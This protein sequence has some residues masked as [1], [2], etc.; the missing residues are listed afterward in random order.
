MCAKYARI[1]VMSLGG[2]RFDKGVPGNFN[3]F[4]ENEPYFPG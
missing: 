4:K 1:M 3:G 2:E